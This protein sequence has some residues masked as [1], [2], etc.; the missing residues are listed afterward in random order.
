M[1]KFG[2]L[3][4]AALIAVSMTGFVACKKT[5]SVK[6]GNQHNPNAEVQLKFHIFDGDYGQDWINKLAET[7]CRVNTNVGI[8]IDWDVTGS[9][10]LNSVEGTN[11]GAK[12]D[13]DV[14]YSITSVNKLARRGFFAEIGDVYDS[15]IPGETKTVR[16]KIAQYDDY[17]N[18]DGKYY[19]MPW[20]NGKVSMLAN[21]TTLKTAYGEDFDAS[22][23]PV[24][25]DE[26]KTMLNDLRDN[27]G[28]N[29]H[30]LMYTTSNCYWGYIF[31]TW[32]AQYQ[33]VDEYFEFYDGKYR[34]ADGTPDI[35]NEVTPVFSSDGQIYSQTGRLRALEVLESLMKKSTG[36]AGSTN[37]AFNEAQL[38]FW[39][40]GYANDKKLGAFMPNGDWCGISMQKWNAR[41][42]QDIIMMRTPVLSTITEVLPGG[43]IAAGNDELL[44]SVVRAI[45][46][47]TEW[48][49]R[50]SVLSAVTENDWNRIKEARYVL[51]DNGTS[52]F[53]AIPKASQNI[54]EAKK[55][56]TF[57]ASDA[58][59]AVWSSSLS[60]M[61]TP[62]NYSIS[63]T[64][65]T[66]NSLI[67]SELEILKNCT[68]IYWDWSTRLVTLGSINPLRMSG[69]DPMI[70]LY[71]GTRNAQQVFDNMKETGDVWQRTLTSAGYDSQ[72][73]IIG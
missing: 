35:N 72:G 30:P 25:T 4:A 5:D 49:A 7:Y 19:A 16:D 21:L 28:E 6:P 52:H 54:D 29:I 33:G 48:S 43:S 15:T 2:A 59:S 11:E 60:G 38:A 56:L 12:S 10:I 67:K 44:Q 45:D 27:H 58:A 69:G 42:P 23:L 65:N 24:T 8:T 66:T 50:A 22:D 70:M 61:I 36:Y 32:W 68:P 39:G 40:H 63:R 20:A 73:N 34:N 17:Y 64:D 37:M 47:G 31:Y 3:L 46:A 51:A 71:E 14:V 41:K 18:I 53:V 9:N 1:K 26:W 57:L 62:Y 55:F 13:Y